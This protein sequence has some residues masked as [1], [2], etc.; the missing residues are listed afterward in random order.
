MNKRKAM[1][2]YKRWAAAEDP[3]AVRAKYKKPTFDKAMKIAK[4]VLSKK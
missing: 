3:E 4:D 2:I 1:K